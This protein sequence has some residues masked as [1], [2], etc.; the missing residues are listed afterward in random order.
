M[1]NNQQQPQQAPQQP[2]YPQPTPQYV[3]QPQVSQDDSLGNWVLTLFLAGIPVIGFIMLLVW[4]F[5]GNPS[6]R[7]NYARAAL[8]WQVIAIVAT[9]VLV[10]LFGGAIASAAYYY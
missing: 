5:G 1:D 10:A 6:G 8:I 9:I 7:R 4:G 2:Y 3:Q